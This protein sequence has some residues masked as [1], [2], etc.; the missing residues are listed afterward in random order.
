MK[1]GTKVIH[2]GIVPD[3]STGAIMTPIYQTS[4]YVQAAPGD[5]K[6]YEYARTQNPTRHALEDNIAAL[7]NGTDAVC[8]A[9]GL[10]AMDSILK[11]LN[12]G[13]E[14]I[15]TDDLYGGSYRL[16]TRV[17]GKYGI[18]FQ[19]VG[20]GDVEALSQKITDKTR[21]IWVET[22]TNPMLNI[23]D[24]QAVCEAVKEKN[25]IVCV[26]NTFASPYLQN[27]LD[28]GAGIVVHS[29]TKYLG[30]HSDVIH[31][32]V[33]TKNKEIAEQIR[34]LQNAVGAVPGPQDCFL[35]LRG[36]KTLHIRVERACQNAEKIATFLKNHTKVSKVYYPGFE[37]H[38]GH[39]IAKKQMKMFGGMVSFDLVAN[40]ESSARKV[41][42][43]THYFSLAESLG[44]VESL[45][46]HPANMTHASIPREERLKVGL[47]DSLIRLSVG[48][49][50]VED[51]I[52][53]LDYALSLV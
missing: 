27:P 35:I 19:Y 23:I 50:D 20:M 51:L 31:G 43:N 3:P 37:D 11:L 10:A 33:V 29:A 52:Q 24:I 36:I 34:F 49:E 25:I 5:H 28:L 39:E 21:M 15:A 18:K 41:L 4:T 9:S 14:V 7:E 2:A 47:T 46:G 30:G 17:F 6:G 42:S 16:M 26:D 1:F 44:G 12:P 48:I 8:F 38:P 40:D 13:D 45:I 53:D 32:V 22:P